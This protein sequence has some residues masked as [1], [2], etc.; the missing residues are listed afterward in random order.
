VSILKNAAHLIGGLSTVSFTH[1]QR[2]LRSFWMKFWIAQPWPRLL[3]II[4]LAAG[5]LG[6]S[7]SL[8]AQSDEDD[9][10]G[11][12]FFGWFG[13]D[14]PLAVTIL[15]PFADMHTGPGR[16]YPIDHVIERGESITLVRRRT[17]WIQVETKRGRRGWV[18]RD[19]LNLTLG[20][21]DTLIEFQEA[22]IEDYRSRRWSGGFGFGD[23]AGADTIAMYLGYRFS[24][25]LSF[26]IKATQAIGSF[27]NNYIVGGSVVHELFPEWRVSPFFAL[28][29][30]AITTKPDATLVQTEDRTDAM[31]FVGIGAHAYISRHFMLRAEYTINLI[32]T[33]R[34]EHE[35]VNE[36]K[37][38]I[39][40]FF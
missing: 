37:L 22:T 34:D 21:D 13:D 15:D 5:L 18:S 28:G 19:A 33:S 2:N 30:G 31:L 12:S 23:F 17:D 26:E 7:Q 35:R 32:L 8:F 14:E 4:S 40:I 27:S 6:S 36:W 10:A 3:A 38:G 16:G 11:G 29:A 1:N 25:N 20:P 24:N 39:N 9:A